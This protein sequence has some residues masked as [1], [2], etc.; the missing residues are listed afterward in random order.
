M[1][2]RSGVKQYWDSCAYNYA[3]II[4]DSC[5]ID[6]PGGIEEFNSANHLFLSPNPAINEIKVQSSKFKVQSVVVMDMMGKRL[7]L[8]LGTGSKVHGTFALSPNG[9]G[10][11][12][13]V[14]LLPAGIYFVRVSGEKNFAIGK[15]V[16]E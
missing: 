11:R 15:F 4:Y 2:F 1:L 10:L 16:K 8:P 5:H 13:D 12:F 3:V 14:S 7:T 6:F 9:E